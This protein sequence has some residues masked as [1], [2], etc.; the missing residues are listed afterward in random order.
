MGDVD[1]LTH[2][3]NELD[4]RSWDLDEFLVD[5]PDLPA[6]IRSSLQ[7]ARLVRTAPRPAPSHAFRARS[8]ASLVTR[9]QQDARR[10]RSRW[11][12]LRD[13]FRPFARP[14]IVPV[15]A[16]ALAVGGMTGVWAASEATIPSAPLYATKLT[17]ERLEALLA[18]SPEQRVTL[19]L[20]LAENR[21]KEAAYLAQAGDQFGTTRLIQQYDREIALVYVIARSQLIPR[22]EVRLLAQVED[23]IAT[24]QAERQIVVARAFRT[25]LTAATQRSS[26]ERAVVE[27]SPPPAAEESLATL[28]AGEVIAHPTPVPVTAYGPDLA[29][30]LVGDLLAQVATGDGVSASDTAQNLAT[31]V[32]ATNVDS[33]S[34]REKLVADQA[35]LETALRAASPST[36]PAVKVAL[37]AIS[38]A[39]PT[40]S[41]SPTPT[42]SATR[43]LAPT[44]ES[45][46]PSA[47]SSSAATPTPTP[48][49]GGKA[50]NQGTHGGGAPGDKKP[51]GPQHSEP[52]HS[53]PPKGLPGAKPGGAHR[54]PIFARP[55]P[56]GAPISP[57]PAKVLPGP[58]PVSGVAQKPAR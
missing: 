19:H 44:S 22:D 38:R 2:Y 25:T 39:A 45:P 15:A 47:P 16:V 17:L 34:A 48:Q 51:G 32:P 21:L 33:P 35:R 37:T 36:A 20:H 42:A 29:D 53:S 18:L 5:H 6:S 12:W 23:Q 46:A 41:P 13:L 56:N 28:V 58:K 54:G 7:V 49:D 10:R 9:I 40:P 11:D 8:R 3:L 57:P 50:P 43:P 27:A 26:G 30:Q 31:V 55:A 4:A 14:L 52:P 1:R 24:L